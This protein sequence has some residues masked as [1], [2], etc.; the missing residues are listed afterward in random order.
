MTQ[1]GAQSKKIQQQRVE[2]SYIIPAYNAEATLDQTIQSVFAQ[3]LENVEAVVVDDGSTDGTRHVAGAMLGPR[4]RLVSQENRGLAAARN[5]GWQEAAGARVCF[6]DADDVVAPTHAA[7]MLGAIGAADAVACGHALVGP[8]L[9]DLGWRVPTLASD[10]TLSRLG[11]GNRIPVGA[12]VLDSARV[13]GLLGGEARF[14]ESLPVVEDWDLW[15]RLARAGARWARPVEGGLFWYRLVPGSMSCDTGLM[16]RTGLGLLDRYVE[17][18]T[19]RAHGVRAWSVQCMA[20]AVAA[21]E[22]GL[23]GEIRSGLGDVAGVGR[24]EQEDLPTLVGALRWS[25]ARGEAVGPREWGRCMPAWTE[26]VREVL[27]DEPI[28]D[29]I[30]HRLAFGPHRWRQIVERAGRMLA[31][32]ERLIVYGFGRNGH[33]AVRAAVDLGLMVAV[34]DDDPH[35]IGK[36]S[37]MRAEDLEAGHLVLVTPEAR[38]G[39]VARL[40]AQG[41]RRIILPDA[42]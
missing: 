23:L 37:S 15:L 27:A 33:E 19:A 30:V 6:L 29:E 17:D 3:S 5:T 36:V 40:E 24:L 41:V 35:A 18:V 21:G 31:P 12:V 26:R 13:R 14:D 38:A 8:G 39:I 11:E 42:A 32:G 20:R 16:W 9:E 10:T 34:V 22:G 1:H 25:L 7:A 2:L 28:V 4:V